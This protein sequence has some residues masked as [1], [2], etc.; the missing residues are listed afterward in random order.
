MTQ[1]S[2]GIHYFDPGVPD[3]VELRWIGMNANRREAAGKPPYEDREY[4]FGTVCKL[5]GRFWLGDTKA[6]TGQVVLPSFDLRRKVKLRDAP[7]WVWEVIRQGY[8][9]AKK[10][11]GGGSS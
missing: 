11:A 5:E 2:L 6:D 9:E 10:S 7:A 4:T 8:E 3:G 1:H